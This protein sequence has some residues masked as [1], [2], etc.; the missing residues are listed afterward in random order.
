[1]APSSGNAAAGENLLEQMLQKNLSAFTISSPQASFKSNI[2]SN[3][4][5]AKSSTKGSV[6][7]ASPDSKVAPPLKQPMTGPETNQKS[8]GSL[9]VGLGSNGGSLSSSSTTKLPPHTIK[10]DN[11]NPAPVSPTKNKTVLGTAAGLKSAWNTVGTIASTSRELESINETDRAGP[12]T[13]SDAS[14]PVASAQR[15]RSSASTSE[16]L[17][18]DSVPGTHPTPVPNNAVNADAGLGVL[19][20]NIRV[21]YAP[22]ATVAQVKSASMKLS[23]WA[24]SHRE[25]IN[26]KTGAPPSSLRVP[27]TP[28]VRQL[29]SRHAQ[30][31]L[32]SSTYTERPRSAFLTA[33]G[34]QVS[35]NAVNDSKTDPRRDQIPEWYVELQKKDPMPSRISSDAMLRRFEALKSFMEEKGWD[36]HQHTVYANSLMLKALAHHDL[37]LLA[38]SFAA[39]ERDVN[40][41]P[42]PAKTSP[43]SSLKEPF[44]KPGIKAPQSSSGSVLKASSPEFRPAGQS[45]GPTFN[46]HPK[47]VWNPDSQSSGAANPQSPPFLALKDT[48]RESDAKPTASKGA[49]RRKDSNPNTADKTSYSQEALLKLGEM[50]NNTPQTLPEPMK[51]DLSRFRKMSEDK[52]GPP[53]LNVEAP[54]TAERDGLSFAAWPNPPGRFKARTCF[55]PIS[56]YRFVDNVLRSN[57][58]PDSQVAPCQSSSKLYGCIGL[59]PDLAWPY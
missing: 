44:G 8:L 10:H 13:L 40:P 42:E 17:T 38:G 37:E 53:S 12:T 4:D 1:M 11:P 50:Y 19:I 30:E 25:N 21:G 2:A 27:A 57:S 15:F 46:I 47:H 58:G 39:F 34:R 14:V 41:M 7:T 23:Q 28:A 18:H 22:D 48:S 43:F 51:K 31:L 24:P 33:I 45:T 6:M 36:K 26:P 52:S 9:R 56:S 54:A 32:V 5:D 59:V 29:V 16:R 20:G 49:A 3:A 35:S 55:P